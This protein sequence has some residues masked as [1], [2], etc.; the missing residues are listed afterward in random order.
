MAVECDGAGTFQRGD[1]GGRRL[2]YS[3]KD[4]L[5]ANLPALVERIVR[6]EITRLTGAAK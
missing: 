1:D 5:D 2:R 3:M 6:E 4:W